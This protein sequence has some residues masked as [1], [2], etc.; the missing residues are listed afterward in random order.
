[1]MEDNNNMSKKLMLI[2]VAILGLS[3]CAM[4]E[5]PAPAAGSAPVEKSMKSHK[6]G[7]KKASAKKSKAGK[8]KNK[9]AAAAPAAAAPAA[10]APAAV[11]EAP[12]APAAKP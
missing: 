8:N 2:A 5:D 4:A 6:G 11:P 3:V 10:A 12:A 1:M 7:H 9:P